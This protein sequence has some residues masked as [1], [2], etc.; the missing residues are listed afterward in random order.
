[1]LGLPQG[2]YTPG[3]NDG[4]HAG[5][6]PIGAED[7]RE[8]PKDQW[9]EFRGF[10][11]KL[12]RDLGDILAD[13]TPGT[14]MADVLEYVPKVWTPVLNLT[15]IFETVPCPTCGDTECRGGW[16]KRFTMVGLN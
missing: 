6:S 12:R 16:V 5:F 13:V 15:W 4:H 10:K 14:D 7:P 1:M 3:P 11:Q 8:Y 2:L 9:V